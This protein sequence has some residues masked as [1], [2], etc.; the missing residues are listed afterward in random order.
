MDYG[1]HAPTV[2]FPVH[3]TLMV[4]PT[5]S[6]P[7][8]ELNRFVEAMIGIRKEIKEIEDGKADKTNNVVIN[9]P[10]TVYM[11][12]DD[13]WEYPYSR[14]KAAFPVYYEYIEKYWTPVT[15][16]DDAFGDRN[17]VCTCVPTE[18]YESTE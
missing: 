9:A 13:N 10:H 16:I 7:L 12:T 18:K 1:F 15:K 5:E 4:E 3:G 11:V 8:A 2:A 17:L 6:E 14:K